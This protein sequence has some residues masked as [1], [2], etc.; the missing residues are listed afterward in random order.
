M[1]PPQRQWSD[2]IWSDKSH[3][4]YRYRPDDRVPGEYVYDYRAAEGDAVP[5]I[6]AGASVN[7]LAEGVSRLRY[8]T[9]DAAH[10][11]GRFDMTVLE[12]ILEITVLIVDS[13]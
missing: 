7:T 6:D 13:Q 3:N 12:L 10:D 8:S 1:P 2:W 4:Y 5:R 9:D 11:D